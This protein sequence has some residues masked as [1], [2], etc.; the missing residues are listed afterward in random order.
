MVRL[1]VLILVASL[2]PAWVGAST[3]PDLRSQIVIDGDAG[4]FAADDW[5]LDDSTSFP[6]RSGDSQWGTD[7]DVLAVAVTWDNYNLYVGVPAVVVSTTLM[8]FLDVGCGGVHDLRGGGSFRRNIEFSAMTPNALFGVIRVLETPELAVVDC[9]HPV[10]TV[11]PAEYQ[12]IYVQQGSEKG[13]LE[14]AVPW[15]LFPGFG[16]EGAGVTVPDDG[17]M[18]RVLAAVTA[19]PGMGA[20][21]AAPDPSVVLENDSTRIAILNNTIELPLDADGDG[22]LDIGVSPR[23]VA[24][25]GVPA[26]EDVQGVLPIQV[27]VADKLIAPGSGQSLQFSISL[28]PPTYSQPVYLT[29]RVYSSTGR[30]LRTLFS[31]EAVLLSSGPVAKTW[32]GRDDGGTMVP[33]GVY[34]IAV[35]GGPGKSASKSTATASFAVIR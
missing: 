10:S 33:G 35:S 18:L 32:D 26:S 31:E 23:S 15:T 11:D 29:G 5:V 12:G 28:N 13:A 17:K 2:L 4:D 3:A 30:L 6:E 24:N 25:Y 20:G 16:R 22:W 27:I 19:G 8:L 7:N 34:V 9:N 1:R 21:D 14:V